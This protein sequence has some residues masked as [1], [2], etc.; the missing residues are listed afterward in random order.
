MMIS[1]WPPLPAVKKEMSQRRKNTARG[2]S[3]IQMPVPPFKDHIQTRPNGYWG[4]DLWLKESVFPS[5]EG[6]QVL[7]SSTGFGT[8]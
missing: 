3:A 5:L 7:V 4:A 8:F 2:R 1:E 6:I